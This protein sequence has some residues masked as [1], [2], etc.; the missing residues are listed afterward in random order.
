LLQVLMAIGVPWHRG[1]TEGH[2]PDIS[3][4]QQGIRQRPQLTNNHSTIFDFCYII[5]K[6]WGA[7]ADFS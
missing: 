5:D 7:Y 6:H 2:K 1:E 3:R 4:V